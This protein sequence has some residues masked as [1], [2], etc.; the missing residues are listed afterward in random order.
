MLGENG[1]LID[2]IR[3][4]HAGPELFCIRI[5]LIR[6]QDIGSKLIKNKDL[7][8]FLMNFQSCKM[9]RV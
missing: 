1:G 7:W 3:D 8:N 5:A 6:R 9:T 2:M 4:S